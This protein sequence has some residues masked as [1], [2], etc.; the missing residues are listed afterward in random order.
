MAVERRISP[1]RV[2]VA[3]GAGR[4][5]AQGTDLGWPGPEWASGRGDSG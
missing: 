1:V 2:T 4:V 3:Q 5:R